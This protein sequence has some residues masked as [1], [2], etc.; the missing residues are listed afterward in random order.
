M[1]LSLKAFRAQ[2]K[3]ARNSRAGQGQQE[4]VEVT[5]ET[6]DGP[7]RISNFYTVYDHFYRGGGNTPNLFM[8]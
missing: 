2:W 4:T 3:R 5:G 8:K 6:E 7:F 1:T